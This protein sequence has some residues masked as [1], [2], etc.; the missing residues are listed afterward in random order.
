MNTPNIG[1]QIS[2]FLAANTLNAHELERLTVA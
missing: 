2:T 1:L